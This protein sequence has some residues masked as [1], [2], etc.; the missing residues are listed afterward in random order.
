MDKS[1][2]NAFLQLIGF[3]K[4]TI[5]YVVFKR[6]LI[7]LAAYLNN[8][9]AK[10]GRKWLPSAILLDWITICSSSF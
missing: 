5:Y 2:P 1:N 8:D 4:K 3:W 10:E 9:R 6:I 7:D